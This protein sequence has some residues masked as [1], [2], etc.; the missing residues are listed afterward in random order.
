MLANNRLTRNP[1]DSG[2]LGWMLQQGALKCIQ[3]MDRQY[4]P[5]DNVLL[6]NIETGQ[7]NQFII[8]LRKNSMR[9][10]EGKAERGWFPGFAPLGYVNDKLEQTI[11]ENTECFLL[12]RRMWDMMLTGNYT[13]PQIREIVNTDW[14][15]RT[16]KR[17]RGGGVELSN[18]VIYKCSVTFST[19]ACFS[20]KEWF[21][22]AIIKQW[23]P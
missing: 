11:Y 7:A 14:G 10:M 16:P 1:V 19:Q 2:T 4:L 3:T 23:L 13:P 9:G 6:F 8:D 21:I 22:K 5:G 20:G 18:S 17:K 15:F 12:V